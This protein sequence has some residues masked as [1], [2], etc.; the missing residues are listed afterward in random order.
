M[1]A[2]LTIAQRRERV[3]DLTALGHSAPQI[4]AAVGCT[5][6]TVV[7][8]RARAGISQPAGGPLTDD[9]IHCARALL[10]D[11]ASFSEVAR[12]LGRSYRHLRGRFPD[13]PGWTRQQG[14]IL[15]AAMRNHGWR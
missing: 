2:A 8:I 13:V 12:T 11:G 5:P 9:E 14:G 7:R 15:S 1:T 4:A 3:V 6:R 10:D